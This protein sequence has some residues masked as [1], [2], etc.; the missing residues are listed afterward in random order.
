MKRS[1]RF[2]EKLRMYGRNMNKLGHELSFFG[3]WSVPT[4]LCQDGRWIP[5]WIEQ[6]KKRNIEEA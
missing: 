1:S 6:K 5:K 3:Y 4:F 2:Y